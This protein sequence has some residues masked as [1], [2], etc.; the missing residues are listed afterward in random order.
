MVMKRKLFVEGNEM[1]LRATGSE[2]GAICFLG[3]SISTGA[4]LEI[5]WVVEG[6]RVQLA[7]S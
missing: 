7:L 5:P 2:V 1:G 3:L 6:S 4:R